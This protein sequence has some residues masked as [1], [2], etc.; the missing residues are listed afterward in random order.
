MT[1]C[2]GAQPEPSCLPSGG[3]C[4]GVGGDRRGPWCLHRRQGAARLPPPSLPR[5]SCVEPVRPRRPATTDV[6]PGAWADARARAV[7]AVLEAR[8]ADVGRRDETGWLARAEGARVRRLRTDPGRRPRAHESAWGP[9]TCGSSARETTA[10]VPAPRGTQV[11]WDVKASLTY[12][13]RGFDTTSASPSTS[14]SPSRLTRRGPAGLVITARRPPGAR[15]PGISPASSSG[16]R[17]TALVLA[18]GDRR[19]GRGG[20]ASRA[21]GRASR[22]APCGER[23]TGRLGRPGHRRRRRP[24]ARSHGRRPRRRGRRH[25]RSA[26]AGGES[27]CGPH[28][29]RP[30]S[31][32]PRCVPTV[33]T[34]S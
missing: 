24:V 18:V 19:P 17:H 21:H 1:R 30:G 32:E 16:G 33:A 31:V 8:V 7:T 6:D 12:R 13:L 25:G 27:R 26:D 3:R 14:T 11:E 28:R 22:V 20:R 5:T 15:N 34:S 10:P 9:V 2:R 4:S 29:P 23:P